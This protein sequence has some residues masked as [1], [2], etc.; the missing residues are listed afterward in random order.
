MST[1]TAP[2]VTSQASDTDREYAKLLWEELQYRHDYGWK[3]VQLW[4]T[5]LAVLATAP[6]IRKDVTCAVSEWLSWYEGLL[7]AAVLLAGAHIAM[8]YF[9]AHHIAKLR[10]SLPEPW[11]GVGSPR[12]RW[13]RP[14]MSIVLGLALVLAGGLLMHGAVRVA[15]QWTQV[16]T[17]CSPTIAVARMAHTVEHAV[18]RSNEPRRSAA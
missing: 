6:F 8:E 13:V 17:T 15:R 11:K 16:P 5:V 1:S 4:G 18:P 9:E 14:W 2:S 7:Q 3:T 10:E 12:A